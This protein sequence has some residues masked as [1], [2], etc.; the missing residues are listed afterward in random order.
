MI[1]PHWQEL[2]RQQPGCRDELTTCALWPSTMTASLPYGQCAWWAVGPVYHGV[3]VPALSLHA[4]PVPG[5]HHD[6]HHRWHHC[7]LRPRLSHRHPHDSLQGLQHRD[8]AKGLPPPTP[9][10]RPTGRSPRVHC[11]ASSVSKHGIGGPEDLCGGCLNAAEHVPDT[12]TRSSE[13]SLPDCSTATTLD[14]QS[15][16]TPGASGTLEAEAEA[17]SACSCCRPRAQDRGPSKGRDPEHQSE[18]F[19]NSTAASLRAC[20]TPPNLTCQ[21]HPHIKTRAPQSLLQVP[22]LTGEDEVQT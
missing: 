12:L 21:G 4:V 2:P 7:G 8:P 11:H 9:T 20:R 19:H 1:P 15:Q 13:T 10:R 5:R 22:D 17:C 18:Q 14:S 3:R 6:H 16:S